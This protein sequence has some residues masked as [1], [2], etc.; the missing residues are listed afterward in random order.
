MS[1]GRAAEK[2]APL[3]SSF[4]SLSHHHHHASNTHI[5]TH[6]VMLFASVGSVIL[7]VCVCVCA[8]ALCKDDDCDDDDD[9]NTRH[10]L[11]L[12]SVC[13]FL[14]EFVCTLAKNTHTHMNYVHV[15]DRGSKIFPEGKFKRGAVYENRTNASP[16]SSYIGFRCTLKNP[17]TTMTNSGDDDLVSL[18]SPTSGE[19]PSLSPKRFS[20]PPKRLPG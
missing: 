20:T 19:S 9:S 12:L 4:W 3:A 7:C 1:E 8:A 15:L 13:E 11:L 5:H 14:L 6:P 10:A 17:M 16:L 18:S 2:G